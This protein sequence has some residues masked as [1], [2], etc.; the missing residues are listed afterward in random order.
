LLKH[1]CFAWG[2]RNGESGV[3]GEAWKDVEEQA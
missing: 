3:F 1:Y 2:W